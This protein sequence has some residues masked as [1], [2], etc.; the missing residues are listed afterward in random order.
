M[1][2]RWLEVTSVP[3]APLS[4]DLNFLRA[5]GLPIIRM[6]FRALPVKAT[7]L[8]NCSPLSPPCKVSTLNGEALTSICY[9]RQ[10]MS[11]EVC[12]LCGACVPVG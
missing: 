4:T 7:S 11:Q 12:S 3:L 10:H 9:C 5:A 8:F 1:F 2:V 6:G